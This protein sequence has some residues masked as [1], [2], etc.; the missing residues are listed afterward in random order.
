M[1]TIH[2]KC[3]VLFS[4]KKKEKENCVEYDQMAPLIWVYANF[5]FTG[6]ALNIRT[7][8]V[9]LLLQYLA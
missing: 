8:L 4:L 3:L 9:L 6:S 5:M 2:M 1:Q 7:T